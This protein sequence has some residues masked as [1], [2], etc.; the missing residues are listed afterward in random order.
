MSSTPVSDEVGEVPIPALLRAARGAYG[1]AV[2]A[3]LAAGKFGD[4]PRNGPLRS[5]WHVS[6]R[7]GC[8]A[9]DPTVGRI[10]AS[11]EPV[12]RPACPRWLPATRHPSGRPPARRSA[13]LPERGRA[14][15]EAVREGVRAV[16]AELAELISPRPSSTVCGP[17]WLRSAISVIG[18]R[19]RLVPGL[20]RPGSTARSRTITV[21]GHDPT[22]DPYFWTM[23]PH[24]PGF[25]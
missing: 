21:A 16:H 13:E 3:R 6:V 10:Q 12:D 25:D 1:R 24:Y 9:T 15:A 11:G 5:G 18:W 7:R 8:R 14:A 22:P 17:A 2:G 23:R 20:R 19:T 4:I